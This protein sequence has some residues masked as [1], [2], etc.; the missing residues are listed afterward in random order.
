MA[1]E[2]RLRLLGMT[3]ATGAVQLGASLGQQIIGYPDIVTLNTP[4][5]QF[6]DGTVLGGN[7]QVGGS[8]QFDMRN[9]PFPGTPGWRP[10]AV[11]W[12]NQTQAV[13]IAS[14]Q[15][16]PITVDPDT[17]YAEEIWLTGFITASSTTSTWNCVRGV[18]SSTGAPLHNSGATVW[19]APTPTD[20]L[21]SFDDP[22]G[23]NLGYD[24]EFQGDTTNAPSYSFNGTQYTWSKFNVSTAVY[25][26]AWGRGSFYLPAAA[27]LSWQGIQMPVPTQTAWTATTK[28]S[29]I[30]SYAD[31]VAAGMYITNGTAFLMIGFTLIST[32]LNLTANE[33]SSLTGGLSAIGTTTNYGAESPLGAPLYFRMQRF[34]STSWSFGSSL[35]GVSWTT[36]ASGINVPGSYFT[37]TNIGIG[38]YTNNSQPASL[39]CQFFR[40]R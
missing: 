8:P 40:V 19:N 9:Q 33:A 4:Y 25:T 27:S 29:A 3:G 38:L 5:L 39:S 23:G 37:P 20:K 28:L 6:A 1:N 22:W 24:Y 10:P 26:E 31:S 18:G 21:L 34:S 36:P 11:I 2:K 15:Y 12:S 16:L 32:S 30:F 7:P 14:D 13:P 17:G 35:D